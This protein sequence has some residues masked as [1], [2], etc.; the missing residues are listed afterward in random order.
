MNKRLNDY[1]DTKRLAFPRFYFV[2]N[3]ELILM[4]AQSHEPNFIAYNYIQQ[5]FDGIKKLELSES[6]DEKVENENVNSNDEDINIKN[7]KENKAILNEEDDKNIKKQELEMYN[8]N[9]TVINDSNN[10]KNKE[11]N[12]DQQTQQKVQKSI[13]LGVR[14][15]THMISELGESIDFNNEIYPYDRFDS[16]E[17]IIYKPM[18]LE[19]WLTDLELEM[20]NTM[21]KKLLESYI[22]IRCKESE[23]LN[24]YKLKLIIK[25]ERQ[26][27]IE[28]L[29]KIEPSFKQSLESSAE[30]DINNI[31]F[32]SDKIT[33]F[34][35]KR[36]EA[37]LEK[38]N[39]D[40]SEMK[41]RKQELNKKRLNEETIIK[42]EK[43]TIDVIRTKW[44]GSCCEQA[45]LTI[46]Q[47]EWTSKVTN[48]LNYEKEKENNH[49]NIINY[50]FE[51]V[52]PLSV[53]EKRLQNN[54][55]CLIQKIRKEKLSKIIKG[56]IVSLIVQDVNALDVVG[57]LI[58]N[59]VKD[60]NSFDWVS[61]LR[62][63]LIKD[64]TNRFK[65]NNNCS[66]KEN[67]TEDNI[68]INL[69]LYSQDEIAN[70][71]NEKTLIVRMLNTEKPYDYEYLGNAKRL[72]ITPLTYRCYRTMMEA[73]N[74]CLGGAPE[75]PAGTG[76]TET[77][78][79]LSRNL[80][81]KNF[82]YNCSEESNY[83]LLTKFFKGI[84]MGGFWICFDEFNRISVDVLSVIAYQI[85]LMLDAQRMKA[86]QWMIE[87]QTLIFNPQ[88]G[89]FITMNPDY[90]G[91]S[92]LPDNL[93][94]LFRPLAMMIPNYEMITEIMLYSFGFA[95]ARS[96]ANKIVNSLKLASEQLS[97][98]VH[99]DY[100]MRT[101]SGIIQY[102]GNLAQDRKID[103]SIDKNGNKLSQEQ[104][105]FEEKKEEEYIAQKAIRDSNM[106]KFTSEDYQIYEG[107]LGD[108]FPNDVY[109]KNEDVMLTSCI[110]ST[111][112]SKNVPC[113]NYIIDKIVDFHNIMSVRH[114]VM[115]VG[116]P[117][118]SKST[119]IDTF[120][121]LSSK[122]YQY[123]SNK[124]Y[125]NQDI[126]ENIYYNKNIQH[127]TINPKSVT[128]SQLFGWVNKKTKEFTEGICSKILRNYFADSNTNDSKLLIFDGPVD[129]LW[130]ENMNSVLDD[131][132]K[133]CLDNSDLIRLDNKTL[134]IFEIDDLSQASLATISR[135]GMV[136]TDRNNFDS[137]DF[138]YSWLNTLPSSMKPENSNLFD[139]LNSLYTF[140]FKPL[141][142]EFIFDEY[143]HLKVKLSVPFYKNWI[144]KNFSLVLEALIFKNTKKS[145]V[146]QNN[147][148]KEQLRMEQ[149]EN[150][151]NSN[152][153]PLVEGS[154]KIDPLDVLKT[155]ASFSIKNNVRPI[156]KKE[157]KNILEKFIVATIITL[158]WPLESNDSKKA[159]QD[160]F[161][162]IIKELT[163]NENFLL[164]DDLFGMTK[165]FIGKDISEILYNHNLD[166]L[167]TTTEFLKSQYEI[168]LNEIINKESILIST[169]DNIKANY[170]L[171]FCLTHNFPLLLYGSSGT[172]KSLVMKNLFK[173]MSSYSILENEINIKL[174]KSGFLKPP[175]NLQTN[176]FII[177][178][179]KT[180]A[181]NLCDI[182]EDKIGNKLKKNTL[183]PGA[184]KTCFMLIEDLN[185]PLKERFGAQPPIEILRQNFDYGGWYDRKENDFLYLKN[186]TFIS[187]MTLG[188]PLVSGRLTWHFLTYY[189][190][191]LDEQSLKSIYQIY[192]S[193]NMHKYPNS[194]RKL[195]SYFTDAIINAYMHTLRIFKPLPTTPH[196]S[197][198]IR[199][200]N[201]IF[202]GFLMIPPESF[203][204][205][206]NPTE[207]LQ[208]LIVNEFLRVVY[209][210]LAN[211]NH[212][213]E[214]VKEV[215]NK[216][217]L[218]FN[219]NFTNKDLITGS[220][221][222]NSNLT[223]INDKAN[224]LSHKT[225]D[226]VNSLVVVQNLKHNSSIIL[227]NN[228][229]KNPLYFDDILYS[230]LN[231]EMSYSRITDIENFKENLNGYLRDYN[232]NKR[233][234]EKMNLIFFDYSLKH[235]IKLDRLF[236]K[237]KENG[238]LI[239]LTGSGR[240]SL[241]L[242]SSFIKKYKIYKI[243]GKD[244]IEDYQRKDWLEDIKTLFIQTGL[245]RENTCFVIKDNLIKDD[246]YY[247]DLNCIISSGIVYN[248]FTNDEKVD[249]ISQLKNMRE[250][251]ELNLPDDTAVW[252]SFIDIAVSHMRVIICLNPLNEDFSKIIRTFPAFVN[253]TYIDWFLNWPE[254]ALYELAKR[255]FLSINDLERFINFDKKSLNNSDSR[256]DNILENDNKIKQSKNIISDIVEADL[257]EED[258]LKQII[259]KENN[260]TN[261]SILISPEKKMI[262]EK[263]SLIFS[264]AFIRLIEYNEKYCKETRKRVIILP[265]T[266]LDCINF[267]NKFALS[268]LKSTT[269]QINKYKGGVNKIEDAEIAIKQMTE[270]LEVKKPILIE[271]D[272]SLQITLSELEIQKKEAEIHREQC[273]IKEREAFDKKEE[274]ENKKS[275]ADFNIAE[276]EEIKN[277]INNKIASIDVKVYSQLR[278]YRVPPKEITKMMQAITAIT[279][280]FEKK[281]IDTLP[282]EWE[283]YKKKMND[284]KYLENLV[285]LPKKLENNLLS[286]KNINLLKPF[287]EDTSLEPTKMLNIS[288]ACEIFCVYFKSMKQL[289][290]LLKT[291][292]IPSKLDLEIATKI[293][294]T[295]QSELDEQRKNLDEV[296]LKLNKLEY[297]SNSLKQEKINLQM[298]ITDSEKKLIRAQKLSTKLVSERSRWKEIGEDL[299]KN[300]EY[301]LG[302]VIISVFYIC[303]LTPYLDIKRE[304]FLKSELFGIIKDSSINLK[305]QIT[306][307]KIVGN[308][309]KIQEWLAN[310]LPS[311]SGNIDNAIVLFESYKP[312][313]LLDPQ[314]QG[315]RFLMKL[316]MTNFVLY[317][318]FEDMNS[319]LNFIEKSIR[320]GKT[321]IFD[322]INYDI[323]TEVETL[324][325]SEV[326]Y[327][328]PEN[329]YSS[330]IT[331]L[332]STNAFNSFSNNKSKSKEK[333]KNL[334]EQNLQTYID[335]LNGLIKVIKLGENLEIPVH[336]NFK[337]FLVS[338]NPNPVFNSELY[339]KITMINF[340]VTKS[341][342]TEQL[343]SIITKEEAPTEEVERMN[344]LQKQSELSEK[345]HSFEEEILLM[346]SY[347]SDM[348]LE[349]DTLINKLEDSKR[350]SDEAN[351]QMNQAKV[352]E[353]RIQN[354]RN[355]YI[356]LANLS[357]VTFF[358]IQELCMIEDIYYFSI[359]WFIQFIL[360]K[361]IREIPNI[362]N[363]NNKFNFKER[364]LVLRNNF[365]KNTY[366][367]VCS[368]LF[369]K[370]KKIFAFLLLT[371]Y[372]EFNGQL[373][374]QFMS[375]F[376][377]G[378]LEKKFSDKDLDNNKKHRERKPNF[379]ESTVIW[380]SLIQLNYL[381]EYKNILDDIYNNTELYKKWCSDVY[382]DNTDIEVDM[383][384]FPTPTFNEIPKF[385]KLLLI[386]ILAID[387]LNLYIDKILNETFVKEMSLIPLFTINNLFEIST[388]TVPL[389]LLLSLGF[390]PTEEVKKL[391]EENGREVMRVSLGQGQTQKTLAA[392]EI[393]QRK[394]EWIF[395][396]NLHL[397]PDFMKTL[398]QVI[399]NLSSSSEK[400]VL[401]TFRL[402]LSALPS[403]D[404][405]P[406]VLMNTTKITLESPIG[407]KSNILKL[408]K[409]QEKSWKYENEVLR[410]VNK[411]YE[412]SKFLISLIYFHSIILERKNYGP[413]GWNIKYN[414]NLSDFTISKSILKYHLQNYEIT[415]LKAINYLFSDCIY[416]GRV[417]ENLDRRTLK[418]I[419]NDFFNKNILEEENIVI[420]NCKEY[421]IDY[422]DDYNKYLDKFE[423]LPDISSPEVVG[424]HK[425]SLIKKDTEFNNMILRVIGN[426]G[427]AEKTDDENRESKT[428]K[429][430]DSASSQVNI[431][432]KIVEESNKKLIKAFNIDSIRSK[433]PLDYDNCMNSIL[434]QEVMRYNSLLKIVFDNLKE[435]TDAYA[436]LLPLTDEIEKMSNSLLANKTPEYWI[437]ISYPSKKPILS[438][439]DDLSK[440]I[441]FFL[442]WEKNGT[443][444]N[445]WFSAFFFTQAFLTGIKQIYARKH[446]V[447]INDLSF[448]FEF[449]VNGIDENLK[450]RINSR[451]SYYTYGLYLEGAEW[452]LNNNILT[453]L[454]NN[455]TY[456]SMPPIIISVFQLEKSIDENNEI[457]GF[458]SCPVYKCSTR[459]GSLSTT[460]HST[461]FVSNIKY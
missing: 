378:V 55:N 145:E 27:K 38:I 449:A 403:K 294:N 321:L 372:S 49:K 12:Q 404:I 114:A 401:P 332:S 398:E 252:N 314:K 181:N 82:T 129:T 246:S 256:S 386:K 153:K 194:I 420:N 18:F 224:E 341:G 307:S 450:E 453:E 268:Y 89:I 136:Y 328:N 137:N 144:I 261:N 257:E 157:K 452:D 79:D 319:C 454:T 10:N 289:D 350:L 316:F 395:L 245:R 208:I 413:L 45:I 331:I 272:K 250:V 309:F 397:V 443:P 135:C 202:E 52:T 405:L 78:K 447:G 93:K 167:F 445:F 393:A 293:Y 69:S 281:Q 383:F 308:P 226:S 64:K 100:G 310:G 175:Y 385:K 255:E 48:S 213:E 254:P 267:F 262:A 271:K 429:V 13:Y 433:F 185:M 227:N 32:L 347:G 172:S 249:L 62:Y 455:R 326:Y 210:R 43:E 11:N 26:E 91:R 188:R 219:K 461:N 207:K 179:S 333:E 360:E 375:F 422:L 266:Y 74:N 156:S 394:G 411:D 439:I 410:K 60:E 40:F 402:W 193:A 276:A 381:D 306:I 222:S 264:K 198:N 303:F 168:N 322:Y 349:N 71:L 280:N 166:V 105:I 7:I 186:T 373:N 345:L 180:S 396:Q 183:A 218:S 416:G 342:L 389:F 116:D 279:N 291:K 20:K 66:K 258:E 446:K 216:M 244:E 165:F 419:L 231:D 58:K 297:N 426:L 377:K 3:E 238:L 123:L 51:D 318:K 324:I 107:I 277:K 150:N 102:I 444:V 148:E 39:I 162:Q 14:K 215:L 77:I 369:N 199:D 355:N 121:Q 346:L 412:F 354:F 41:V 338:Y 337:F 329:D 292:L 253:N 407:V 374:N 4:L 187:C 112:A 42:T 371:R 353:E 235:F 317:K 46:S 24:L 56:T 380:D 408:L 228:A 275:V 356:T 59:N 117:M 30:C 70:I 415:P 103:Y 299:E 220:F 57:L 196:Y 83:E 379:I 247:V 53:L 197:Y 15:M 240:E 184:N 149:D 113:C 283:Y 159:F 134:I 418:A 304:A 436:G 458:Y 428:D 359:N 97:S 313:L 301:L 139:Y 357:S 274:A 392:I 259:N 160:R 390:D 16:R 298:E 364:N 140:I 85:S 177:L 352:S 448:S 155:R 54:L 31:E 234:K 201:K 441:E 312:V 282:T 265:K 75:G 126:P 358:S 387:K 437:K 287:I 456:Y 435:I 409:S 158:N 340:T 50:D 432:N 141:L 76:K 146:I 330:V 273:E 169:K 270:I 128:S 22:N 164:K 192:Y 1:L 239:G 335:P 80:G 388:S 430:N 391:A 122:Y 406:S 154:N 251:E 21:R 459:Q 368:S 269:N 248:L 423:M 460:G 327:L 206:M 29:L 98:Q 285:S 399:S 211:E 189:F 28:N 237:Q 323:P 81:K 325:N 434:I 44:V 171:N 120:I 438:W 152:A 334:L 61:Q 86:S 427:F 109:E 236:N 209:D 263:L 366:D 8:L 127:K 400:E 9:S 25:K 19:R 37:E 173:E 284:K 99:Y 111:L 178:N 384:D 72:V 63:Y 6:L 242:L 101:L 223:A 440:R 305:E 138:F 376:F 118:T 217:N 68:N 96:L 424:L 23:S 65:K 233:A 90:A 106:P 147:I 190:K 35:F 33:Q 370:D 73:M 230:D 344:I 124:L 34:L 104:S 67:N 296:E 130:I 5:S 241:T 214:F 221:D 110:K 363:S 205:D 339:G 95:H 200:L 382:L 243:R 119:I 125:K 176:S 2:S 290:E 348:L 361:S 88:M 315:I 295:A 343:L 311:D 362:P 132:K 87:K 421:T 170:M 365:L 131:T 163:T 191:D 431:I 142:S 288:S 174:E 47:L 212:R 457:D 320:D 84:S 94:G 442:E 300:L 425:N 451:K 195:E 17:G 229:N 232:Q 302:D 260:N 278:T 336:P 151:M 414:F 182:M 204:L 203:N 36:E 225:K 115:I 161:I 286:E 108:L 367:A 92:D 351:I 133:L 143:N 417:T